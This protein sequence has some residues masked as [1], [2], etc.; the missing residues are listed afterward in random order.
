[1]TFEVKE[2][3]DSW[4]NSTPSFGSLS[5]LQLPLSI[6]GSIHGTV[7]VTL[8]NTLGMSNSASFALP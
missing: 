5:S 1:M 3:F 2:L 8:R 6:Q 4:F 7:L